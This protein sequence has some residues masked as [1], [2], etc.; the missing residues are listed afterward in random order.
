M[1]RGL[2]ILSGGQDSTTCLA[3]AVNKF[4]EV[5]AITFDYG[6]RHRIEIE[7]AKKI[8]EAFEVPHKIVEL[9][10]IQQVAVSNLITDVGNINV[11]HSINPNLPSSF[12]PGRNLVFITYAAAYAYG[13][14]INNLV[15]GVCETDY[16]GYPDCRQDTINALQNAINLGMDNNFKIHTP[17]MYLT[18]A[19][20]I[21]L[22]SNLGHFE[23]LALSQ[24]CYNGVR[25]GCKQCPACVIRAAGFNELGIDDPLF[26]EC[27]K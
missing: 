12:V 21:E 6:Q 25:P 3:W 13:Q 23:K 24:T 10:G 2:V 17:L 18:K 22:I 14:K 15:T 4:D 27:I 16:S 1:S 11:G 8:A 26:M 5:H 19:E 7:Q 20:T 9:T